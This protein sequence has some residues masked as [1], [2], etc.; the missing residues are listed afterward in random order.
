[1]P[2][3]PCRRISTSASPA[4]LHEHIAVDIGVDAVAA[5]PGAT[6]TSR[7]PRHRQPPR[8]RPSTARSRPG[9]IPK[10]ATATPSPATSVRTSRRGSLASTGPIMPRCAIDGAAEPALI[11]SLHSFTP[12]LAQ[13]RRAAAVGDRHSLQPDDRAAR[14]AFPLLEAEGLSVGDQLPY[15]GRDAQRDDEPACRGAGAA[16]SGRRDAAG[17]CRRR[18]DPP[19]WADLLWPR[20][21]NR[22]AL[23][24]P[25]VKPFGKS[26]AKEKPHHDTFSTSRSCP[27]AM[28]RSAPS[29]RRIAAIITRWG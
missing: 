1:M 6:T 23:A 10:P 13:P 15:S 8:L 25:K 4:L 7:A 9:V 11:L 19:A 18:G 22:V 26:A 29:A 27:A 14:I 16:L 12:R 5:L 17:P 21:R 2:R 28:C 3:T 24:L 20:S